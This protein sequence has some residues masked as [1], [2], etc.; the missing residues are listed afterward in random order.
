MSMSITNK[1]WA[2]T[3]AL[4][5]V[6]IVISAAVHSGAVYAP[7]HFDDFI[8]IVENPS[9]RNTRYLFQYWTDPHTFSYSVDAA[10]Y[11]PLTMTSYL[12]N[13]SLRSYRPGIWHI[14]NLIFH[15]VNVFLVLLVAR[16][17]LGGER[18]AAAA[19]LIFG[20]H[21]L[22]VETSTYISARSGLM[23]ATFGLAA[24]L[25]AGAKDSGVA[26]R[27]F[28]LTLSALLYALA[29]A[30]KENSASFPAIP[31]LLGISSK[32]AQDRRRCWLT[33]LIWSVVLVLY[34]CWRKWGLEFP[35]LPDKTVR[36]LSDNFIL[37]L[38][39][40]AHYLRILF[41]PW[42]LSLV[43]G[44]KIKTGVLEAPGP[45]MLP[46]LAALVLLLCVV[47]WAVLK[48]RKSP[49]VFIGISWFFITIMP[50]TLMPL[51]QAANDRRLYFPMI[52][53]IIA[54]VGYG[55]G[56]VRGRSKIWW[57][58]PLII[59]TLFATLSVHRVNQWK[60]GIVIWAD[61]VKQ[62]PNITTTW[63]NLGNSYVNA[64]L[65]DKG[66]HTFETANNIEPDGASLINIG[67]ILVKKNRLKEAADIF[68]TI[69]ETYPRFLEG[70]YN[71]GTVLF[72]LGRYNEAID[73]FKHLLELAPGYAE[74]HLNMGNCLYQLGNL[75][76]AKVE[77]EEAIRLN[78]ELLDARRNL[79]VV[80]EKLS[81]KK[82][83]QDGK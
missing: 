63:I 24:L 57:V 52:G 49:E 51:N 81:E 32:N 62:S 20:V 12:L 79:R 82:A 28:K 37:Q 45:G 8:T 67:V 5:V 40:L 4:Y 53:I 80:N 74:G 60:S 83:V 70:W 78:P 9:V 33:A 30:S 6:V 61:N 15:L 64:G 13:Y 76:G 38:S 77:Y 25:A 7:F 66:L 39:V 2:R 16:R 31:L 34:L 19:G 65:L 73:A 54:A 72:Q 11:R 75:A 69:V 29:L 36:S 59:A 18:A 43:Y 17:M 1:P 3:G 55:A 41:W 10:M 35:T 48:V 23:A 21:P 47:F 68:T 42:G 56:L 58:A 46:P 27:G 22:V 50:E 26:R 14:T 71:L 44:V